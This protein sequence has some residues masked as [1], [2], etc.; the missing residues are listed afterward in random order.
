MATHS[1]LEIVEAVT[2]E[3]RHYIGRPIS[4]QYELVKSTSKN[5]KA[6]GKSKLRSKGGSGYGKKNSVAIDVYALIVDWYRSDLN[7]MNPGAP[8]FKGKYPHLSNFTISRALNISEEQVKAALEFLDHE[9]LIHRHFTHDENYVDDEGRTR[10]LHVKRYIELDLDRFFEVTYSLPGAFA[11]GGERWENDAI[12]IN[13]STKHPKK[14]AQEGEGKKAHVPAIFTDGGEK[15]PN[16]TSKTDI[17]DYLDISK[18]KTKTKTGGAEIFES[19]ENSKSIEAIEELN[20]TIKMQNELLVKNSEAL[21]M[22]LQNQQGQMPVEACEKVPRDKIVKDLEDNKPKPTKP[23]KAKKARKAKK[24]KTSPDYV[25]KDAMF[26]Q[27]VKEQLP[28]LAD[29]EFPLVP[30]TPEFERYGL[31][32]AAKVDEFHKLPIEGMDGNGKQRFRAA[33]VRAHHARAVDIFLIPGNGEDYGSRYALTNPEQFKELALLGETDGIQ[34][35]FDFRSFPEYW[36]EQKLF[37]ET[38]LAY[39]ACLDSYTDGHYL[40]HDLIMGAVAKRKALRRF[41][42]NT[43][44]QFLHASKAAYVV[45]DLLDENFKANVEGCL[46][47]A[48]RYGETVPEGTFDFLY[49]EV[50]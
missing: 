50:A 45:K 5:P 46:A 31:I 17:N 21:E 2:K 16:N 29:V 41:D 12:S 13:I 30:K 4:W 23:K 24:Q 28:E 39:L 43:G 44:Y 35:L 8:L 40:S 37:C 27:W 11:P 18:T 36:H 10:S 33:V 9:G 48:A 32:V 42:R 34:A 26:V 14:K 25:S 6:H 47:E 7:A 1:R 49:M 20:K 3:M 22:L 19:K 38:T 15:C